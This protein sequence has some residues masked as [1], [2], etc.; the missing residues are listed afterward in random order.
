MASF[1]IYPNLRQRIRRFPLASGETFPEGAPVQINASGEAAVSD[2]DPIAGFAL[3]AAGE[4]PETGY[5][6]VAL[7]LPGATFI[8][9]G[10]RAPLATD[11]GDNLG[12]TTDADSDW[13]VDADTSDCVQIEKVYIGNNRDQF[14]FSVLPGRR[15]FETEAGA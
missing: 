11:V 7:A 10:S 13:I 4:L 1:Q 8:G 6:L 2:E 12:L 14:E 3:H 15:Q 9:Q 5:V